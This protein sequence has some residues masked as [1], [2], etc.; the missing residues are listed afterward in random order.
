MKLLF[1]V[2]TVLSAGSL[3]AASDSGGTTD[4][5]GTLDSSFG[6]RGLV[7]IAGMRSCLPGE[8]GCPMSVGL[9]VQPDGVLL[10]AAGTLERPIAVRASH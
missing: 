5:A 2:A 4:A 10:V 9:V 3:L 6:N 1:V 7:R 8:G